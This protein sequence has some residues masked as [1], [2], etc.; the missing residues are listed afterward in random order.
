[1]HGTYKGVEVKL[2]ITPF[3]QIFGEDKTKEHFKE[4]ELIGLVHE[5]RGNDRLAKWVAYDMTKRFKTFASSR[6]KAIYQLIHKIN[7]EYA[8]T[9]AF[10]F[11]QEGLNSMR[12]TIK[13]EEALYLLQSKGVTGVGFSNATFANN[14]KQHPMEGGWFDLKDSDID[15]KI[16]EDHILIDLWFRG[17]YE[18]GETIEDERTV[19]ME[20]EGQKFY[21]K[22]IKKKVKIMVAD[23]DYVVSKGTRY[24]IQKQSA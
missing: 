5:Q 15:L 1:M 6:I 22:Q 8:G 13:K 14:P 2:T 9:D 23:L 4:P 19:E 20:R 24:M 3:N 16:R 11:N 7:T 18:A 21:I 12:E 10:H 17:A